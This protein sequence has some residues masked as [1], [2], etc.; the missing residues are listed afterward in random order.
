MEHDA[1]LLHLEAIA[2]DNT[3]VNNHPEHPVATF[4]Y[5]L[6]ADCSYL[7]PPSEVVAASS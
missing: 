1:A 2:R 7:R 5:S 4:K 3:Y 6:Q